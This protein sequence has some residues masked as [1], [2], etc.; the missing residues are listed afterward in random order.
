MEIR[1]RMRYGENR[2]R[3]KGV[4]IEFDCNAKVVVATSRDP[5]TSRKLYF[6]CPYQISDVSIF[7]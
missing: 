6:S 7:C 3:N 2:R 4:P 5:I 1:M